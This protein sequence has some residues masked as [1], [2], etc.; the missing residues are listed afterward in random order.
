MARELEEEKQLQSMEDLQSEIALLKDK[1]KVISL[2][3]YEVII[4]GFSL[5]LFDENCLEK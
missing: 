4:V 3:H 5:I 2:P 1:E